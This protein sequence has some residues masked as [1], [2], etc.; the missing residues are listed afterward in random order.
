MLFLHSLMFWKFSL[1]SFFIHSFLLLSFFHNL[2]VYF[3]SL[4]QVSV[5]FSVYLFQCYSNKDF[6]PGPDV[7][8]ILY[9]KDAR[10]IEIV[11]HV[12]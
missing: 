10:F 11:F 9:M 5:L 3:S 7:M 12:P 2:L 8:M 1:F 4:P 6:V